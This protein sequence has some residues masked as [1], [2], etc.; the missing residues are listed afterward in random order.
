MNEKIQVVK[1]DLKD[2]TS[3]KNHKNISIYAKDR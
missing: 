2:E 1:N 3:I